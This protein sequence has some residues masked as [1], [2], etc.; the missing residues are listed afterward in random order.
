[1]KLTTKDMEHLI[2]NY[3]W[4]QGTYLCFEVMMPDTGDR[5]MYNKE[6][7]DLL[8]YE[9]KGYWRFYELKLTKS[10][11]HSSNKVTFLGHYNYYVMPVELYQKVRDE[12]PS[13]VGV[14]CVYTRGDYYYINGCEKRA[15]KQEL[16]V[17][18]D[19]LMFAFMQS[20]SRENQKYRKI[21][22]NDFKKRQDEAWKKKK[23]EQDVMDLW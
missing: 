23:R 12:I 13:H 1:M 16:Q 10:D 4:K 15:R 14:Y 20:L 2:Y 11:F 6:R 9:T 7:V 8:S 22:A 19:S 21:L 3:L 18:H 17:D 5:Y